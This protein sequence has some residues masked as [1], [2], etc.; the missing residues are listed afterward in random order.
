[1]REAMT[2][3][4]TLKQLRDAKVCPNVLSLFEGLFGQAVEVT[5]EAAEAVASQFD[6]DFAASIFLTAPA[7]DEYDWAM[8]HARAEC[9][10][11]TDAARDEYDR[12]TAAARAEC[13]RVTDAAWA[14]YKRVM[15]PARDEYKRVRAATFARLYV[16]DKP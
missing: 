10:R 14:E 13:E 7:R 5:V 12:V 9:E 3:E 2:R 6:F 15:A 8:G 16:S 1:M 4:I 11:V